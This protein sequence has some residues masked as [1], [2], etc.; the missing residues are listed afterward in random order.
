MSFPLDLHS[1]AVS[2]SH[3]PCRAHA[4]HRPCRAS[5]GHSTAV[6]RRPCCAV[7]LR[8]TAWSEHCMASVNQTRPHCVNQMG[9]THSKPLAARH[10]VCES[11]LKV[12]SPLFETLWGQMCFGI[13]NFSEFRTAVRCMYR[14]IRDIASSLWDSTVVSSITISTA[15]RLNIHT[16]RETKTD[17]TDTS[18]CKPC[19]VWFKTSGFQSFADFGIADKGLWTC[20]DTWKSSN[21]FQY[22]RVFSVQRITRSE[23]YGL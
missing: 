6:E 16:K 19:V 11:A 15:K 4:M 17:T 9:K 3:L 10:A 20:S 2:D 7:A 22:C 12:H 18:S 5:Q 21:D 1:A 14:I 13:Q 23:D 8:R